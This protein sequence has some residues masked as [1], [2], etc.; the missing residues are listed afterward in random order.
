M[1]LENAYSSISLLA[2]SLGVSN[3][4]ELAQYYYDSTAIGVNVAFIGRDGKAMAY[5]GDFNHN[6]LRPF[7][8]I[9]H[10]GVVGIRFGTIVEGSD[11][12]FT[13]DTV[14]FPCGQ[15]DITDALS[16]LADLVEEY[17]VDA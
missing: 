4:E 8:S 6:T 14:F 12:E 7:P 10:G 15:S 11:A 5:S 16:H 13:A 1:K 2:D 3:L 9:W 17:E